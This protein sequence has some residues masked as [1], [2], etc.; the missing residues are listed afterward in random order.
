MSASIVQSVKSNDPG[1]NTQEIMG[2]LQL[3]AGRYIVMQQ[4]DSVEPNPLLHGNT[5]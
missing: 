3:E 1:I 5:L 2:V 4:A